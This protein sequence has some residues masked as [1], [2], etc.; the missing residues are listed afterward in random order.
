MA[1]SCYVWSDSVPSPDAAALLSCRSCRC[2]RRLGPGLENGQTGKRANGELKSNAK[3]QWAAAKPMNSADML[4][5]QAKMTKAKM[6][7]GSVAL[8]QTFTFHPPILR[9]DSEACPA[10]QPAGVG[11]GVGRRVVLWGLW[12]G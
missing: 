1:A 6:R 3:K 12:C 10:G 2:H 11:R 7:P 8:T 9:L 5:E 4:F